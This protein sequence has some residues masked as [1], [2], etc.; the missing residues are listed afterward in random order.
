MSAEL[1][2]HFF[3]VQPGGLGF[4]AILYLF[5]RNTIEKYDLVIEYIICP[6]RYFPQFSLPAYKQSSADD[7][8][9]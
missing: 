7:R 6:S 3:E 8:V 4:S 2:E 9:G 5:G 1:F